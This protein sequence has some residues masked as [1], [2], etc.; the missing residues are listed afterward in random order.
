[1]DMRRPRT[2]DALTKIKNPRFP[3]NAE[4]TETA[5]PQQSEKAG[6]GATVPD[7]KPIEPEGS[8]VSSIARLKWLFFAL[9]LAYVLISAYHV[10]I[11]T[12]MGRYLV[13]EQ[14][15]VKSDLIVCLGGGNGVERALTAADVYQ[16]GLAPK[17]FV[18]RESLPDGYEVLK[19]KGVSYLESRDR[20]VLLL[21]DLHVPDSAI[22]TSETPLDSTAKEAALVAKL[23]NEKN[24][25]SIILVTSPPHSRRAWLAFKKATSEGVRV[26][27]VPSSYSRFNAEGWWKT[28]KSAKEVLFEYQK[29]I[30]YYFKGLV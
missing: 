25:R 12:S 10:L 2:W 21:K 13:V 22:L 8:K 16:R 24:F 11:L 18:P 4:G 30:Y 23:A 20:T 6:E 9:A 17:I 5:S 19:R 15:P 3:W 14:D 26:G 29:L 7:N 1:M 27:V 28:P